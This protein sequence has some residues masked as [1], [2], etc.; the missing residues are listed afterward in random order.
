MTRTRVARQKVKVNT[1]SVNDPFVTG[2]RKTKAM[3]RGVSWALASWTATSSAE[4]TNTTK[5]NMDAAIVPSTARAVSGGMSDTQP[6]AP[7]TWCSTR[8]NPRAAATPSSG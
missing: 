5:V 1:N 4:E 2:S 6:I 3:T 8:T 7:S